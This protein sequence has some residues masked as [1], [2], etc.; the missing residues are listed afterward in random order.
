MTLPQ[1]R[2]SR[3]GPA[4]RHHYPELVTEGRDGLG[5]LPRCHGPV[6]LTASASVGLSGGPPART[7]G[8]FRGHRIDPRAIESRDHLDATRTDAL[9]RPDGAVEIDT[10]RLD[11]DE[12]VERVV[13][14]VESRIARRRRE[15]VAETLVRC[16]VARVDRCSP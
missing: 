1:V 11:L 9:V 16:L 14:E 4:G 15:D 5:R 6:L 8:P 13:A 3:R 12:V 7:G 2:S 10:D